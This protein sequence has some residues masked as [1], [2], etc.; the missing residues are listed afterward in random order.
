M[1]Q[2][3]PLFL[4]DDD[5]EETVIDIDSF[6]TKNPLAVVE[7]IDDIY[8]FYR[9]NEVTLVFCFCI[10]MVILVSRSLNH[11]IIVAVS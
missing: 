3:N 2:K 11:S 8:D 9:T 5:I 1:F 4:F 10:T 6:S 7:Y